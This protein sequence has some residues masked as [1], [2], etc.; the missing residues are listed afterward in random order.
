MDSS[1][2]ERF[3]I[4]SRVGINQTLIDYPVQGYRW[5]A[6]VV[7]P[8]DLENSDPTVLT[9]KL[10]Q[11][12]QNR[13]ISGGPL[14][15]PTYLFAVDDYSSRTKPGDIHSS[16]CATHPDEKVI[17]LIHKDFNYLSRESTASA[18]KR[19]Q[20]FQKSVLVLDKPQSVRVLEQPK[21]L[22]S[23]DR[24]ND[25]R[26][27]VRYVIEGQ[28]HSKY[29]QVYMTIDHAQKIDAI[30]KSNREQELL[31]LK[32]CFQKLNQYRK[33]KD[34]EPVKRFV[35]S[36]PGGVFFED[37]FP[38]GIHALRSRHSVSGNTQGLSSLESME[39]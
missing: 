15:G 4:I 38:T 33:T 21:V 37:Y 27:L 7:N 16:T 3:I 36:K 12:Y 11:A 25:H 23:R 32:D 18:Q 10:M 1:V 26:Q 19:M 20:A 31:Q 29:G 17:I 39:S 22:D 24:N 6:V 13:R 28:A 2:Q 35:R 5:A 9:M 30:A 34:S 8:E 14:G